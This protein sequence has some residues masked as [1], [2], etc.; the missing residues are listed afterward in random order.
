MINEIKELIEKA[1]S[2]TNSG[3]RFLDDRW[4]SEGLDNRN[5]HYRRTYYRFC[6]ELVRKV[7]PKIIVELGIDEGDCSGHFAFGSPNAEVYGVDVHKDGEAPSLRCRMVEQQFPNFKYLRGWT[8]DKLND[9]K[10]LNR[11]ID[12][13]Y[14]DSWHEYD[15]F[16]RDWND[17]VPLIAKNAI[18]L[19]DDLHLG[20]IINAFNLIPGDK[21][22]DSTMNSAVPFGIAWNVDKTHKFTHKKRDYMP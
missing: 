5:K 13:L 15:Y 10:A 6:M 11:P 18:V 22:I 8:W 9:I 20:E 1:K 14:I 4:N 3:H 21:Y 16:A 19:V 7:N 17:Y 2:L 12:I